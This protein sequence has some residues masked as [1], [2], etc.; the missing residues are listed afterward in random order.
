[1]GREIK[2]SYINNNKSFFFADM[3]IH[4]EMFDGYMNEME[5]QTAIL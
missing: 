3:V 1:M 5:K 4:N 2:K